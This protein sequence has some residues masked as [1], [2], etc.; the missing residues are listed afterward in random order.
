[1]GR[2]KGVGKGA[3]GGEAGSRKL[4][5]CRKPQDRHAYV[6]PENLKGNNNWTRAA[7]QTFNP[8]TAE[9]EARRAL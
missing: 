8:S 3:E 4:H 6:E 9:A 2:R 5:H 1:M 7:M